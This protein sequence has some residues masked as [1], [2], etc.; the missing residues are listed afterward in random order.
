ML[1]EGSIVEGAIVLDEPANLPEGTRVR[2][3]AIC[4]PIASLEA[5]KQLLN[6]ERDHPRPA[7]PLLAER[8]KDFLVHNIQLPADAASRVDS[9][10]QQGF[11]P[12]EGES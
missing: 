5:L 11:P 6:Q 7:G 9:Y 3:E 4:Q 1:L 8:L 10:L 2:V 12:A